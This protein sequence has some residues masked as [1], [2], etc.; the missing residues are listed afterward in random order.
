MLVLFCDELPTW[1]LRSLPVCP[2]V[3]PLVPVPLCPYVEPVPLVPL[4]P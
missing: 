2:Y 1:P 4:C 3:E